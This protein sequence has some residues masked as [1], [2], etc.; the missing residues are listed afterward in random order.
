M[1]SKRVDVIILSYTANDNLYNTTKRCVYSYLNTAKDII[2]KIYVVETNKN[3]NKDY[4]NSCVE[5]IIPDEQFNYNRFYNIA[6]ERCDAEFII[7]PNNDLILQPNC[8]QNML[9]EFDKDPTLYSL[10]PVDRGHYRHNLLYLPG[11]NKIYSG[12]VNGLHMLGC[13]FCCRRSL[14]K[15]I[16]YMDEQFYFFYQDDD[17][18]KSLE[19]CNLKHGVYT[20]SQISHGLSQSNY[21]ADDRFK[22]TPENMLRQKQLFLNKWYNSEPFMSGGYRPYKVY[23][24]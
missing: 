16:G 21:V 3:F 7:G 4:N 13:L 17:Y 22:Y 20:G 10:S 14:F 8:I 11:E 24:K 5:V 18:I 2:N 12:Y 19:R 6:L 1:T 15:T 9:K 23:N